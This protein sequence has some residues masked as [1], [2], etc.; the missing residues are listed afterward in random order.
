MKKVREDV[1]TKMSNGSKRIRADQPPQT[2]KA[3][4]AQWPQPLSSPVHLLF[5]ENDELTALQTIQEGEVLEDHQ[6]MRAN[7][8]LAQ[9]AHA[10]VD[11]MWKF[12]HGSR[13]NR[14]KAIRVINRCVGQL[15]DHGRLANLLK[16]RQEA[17]TAMLAFKNAGDALLDAAKITWKEDNVWLEEPKGAPPQPVLGSSPS[18]QDLDYEDEE[19]SDEEEE[20]EEDSDEQM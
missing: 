13:P 6:P 17:E 20:E 8:C 3:A 5:I 12:L 11:R 19:E 1:N 15:P 14:R 7:D 2:I 16:L 9:R 4:L 10:G 18:S